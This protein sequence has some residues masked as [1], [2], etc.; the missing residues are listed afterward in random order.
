[1]C[2]CSISLTS[3]LLNFLSKRK[4]NPNLIISSPFAFIRLVENEN[5][6]CT[7]HES[8]LFLYSQKNYICCANSIVHPTHM[9]FEVTIL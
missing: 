3:G 8:H 5:A 4:S 9:I 1:M 7:E 6:L 2:I